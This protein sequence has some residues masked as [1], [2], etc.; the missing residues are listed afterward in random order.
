[1]P[2]E[3]ETYKLYL[4]IKSHFTTKSYD[5]HKYRGKVKVSEESFYKR[6]DTKLFYKLGKK[7]S[8]AKLLDIFVSNFVYNP[9]LWIGDFVLT[10]E[11]EDTYTR[12]KGIMEKFSYN[13]SEECFQLLSWAE[14]NNVKFNDLFTVKGH[15]HPIIVKMALQKVLSLET[16]V[17]LDML[18]KF[19]KRIDKKIDDPIW[20]N[21]YLKSQKYGV[22]L[23]IDLGICRKSLK[24]MI[25]QDFSSLL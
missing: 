20:K 9:N 12:W 13:F 18:L 15:D 14:K 11:F 19:G 10:N 8:A 4:S 23:D 25:E 24:K 22:F 17:A 16:F 2:N 6:R 7:Y 3:L 5:Y 1:M 21:L